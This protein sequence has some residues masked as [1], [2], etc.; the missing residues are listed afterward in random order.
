MPKELSTGDLPDAPAAAE[1]RNPN[2]PV[3]P[4]ESK[5]SFREDDEGNNEMKVQPQIPVS[6]ASRFSAQ[7]FSKM[8]TNGNIMPMTQRSELHTRLGRFE[9]LSAIVDSGATVPVMNPTT[10]AS[11]EV[12]PGSANGT[13]Y[14]IANGETI[15]DMGEK[16]MAVLTTEGSLRGYG[17]RCADVTKAL[18]SVRALVTSDHAVCFGLGDG[19]DHVIIN[20]VTGEVNYMR[21][22]GINYLQDLL[23][24]PPD[25]VE[26]VAAQLGAVAVHPNDEPSDGGMSQPFG[27]PGR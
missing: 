12:V 21:D 26:Q 11:Y 9:I 10:G 27:R 7:L 14:E 5:V 19:T 18:Q 22:D 16:R 24:V 13:E 2:L 17:S 8:V 15:E 3:A 6:K 20:K 1:P 4:E 23:I 25:L